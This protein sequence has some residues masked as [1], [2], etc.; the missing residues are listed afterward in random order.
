MVAKKAK[1]AKKAKNLA[2]KALSRK[3]AKGVKGGGGSPK[4]S[5]AKKDWIDIYS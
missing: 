5:L 3:Q 1:A 4:I 2:P